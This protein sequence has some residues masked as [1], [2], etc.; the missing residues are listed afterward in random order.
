MNAVVEKKTG[1]LRLGNGIAFPCD[2]T[3]NTDDTFNTKLVAKVGETMYFLEPDYEMIDTGVGVE[4][5]KMIVDETCIKKVV[6]N[7]IGYA[8]NCGVILR[9]VTEN[10]EKVGAVQELFFTTY[11]KAVEA[12]ETINWYYLQK[13]NGDWI[14]EAKYYGNIQYRYMLQFPLKPQDIILEDEHH[15]VVNRV[16]VDIYAD[17]SKVYYQGHDDKS[18]EA[19]REVHTE[20]EYAGVK[21][22][23]EIVKLVE[24]K[25]EVIDI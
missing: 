11:E 5:G 23:Y 18:Y 22:K 7:Y 13:P 21:N 17:Q 2:A 16:V 15:Y 1:T 4:L 14:E 12:I 25:Q 20:H 9:G 3:L 10:G 6:I 24:K 8:T 19:G